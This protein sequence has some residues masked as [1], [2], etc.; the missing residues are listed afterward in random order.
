L[1]YGAG[2]YDRFLE[3]IRTDAKTIGVAFD[4][5]ILDTVPTEPHDKQLDM[6][7]TEIRNIF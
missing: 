6:I 2:L 3:N 7:V 1:G 4:F 5:Q